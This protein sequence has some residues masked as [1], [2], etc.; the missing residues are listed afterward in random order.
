MSS[1]GTAE[2]S[3]YLLC[4]CP[5]C[6]AGGTSAAFAATGI[7]AAEA[8]PQAPAAAILYSSDSTVNALLFISD[9]YPSAR[10][11]YPSGG[12]IGDTTSGIGTGVALTYSFFASVPSYYNGMSGSLVP[13]NATFQAFTETQKAATRTALADVAAITGLTFTEVSDSGNG[14]QIRLGSHAMSGAGGYAYAPSTSWTGTSGDIWMN[15]YATNQDMTAGGYGYL[16]LLHEIGHALG[17]KHTFEGDVTLPTS[18]DTHQW[19]VMSY[20]EQP[21]NIIYTFSGSTATSKLLEPESYSVYDILALQYLYGVNT[22][23]RSGADTY[24]WAANAQFFDTIWDAGGTDTIDLSN[25]TLTSRISLTAGTQSSVNR[26]TTDAEKKIGW[27]NTSYSVPSNYFNGENNLG[28]AFGV[29]IE[30]VLLGSGNDSVIGNSADNQLTGNGGN[31]TLDGGA[32]TDTAIYKGASS[33][34]KIAVNGSTVTVTDSSGVEGVDTLTNI[35]FLKFSDKTVSATGSSTPTASVAGISVTEG[36]SGTTSATFTVTL[37]E[38][39]ATA[40]TMAYATASGTATSGVDFTAASGTLT[41]AA[42]QTTQTVSVAVIGD[43]AVEADETFTL[44]FTNPS[45]AL[46]AGG[47]TSLSA[48]GTIKND[49]SVASAAANDVLL[50]QINSPATTSAAVGND[51]YILSS[52]TLGQAGAYTLTDVQGSNSIQLV[53]GLTLS[54]FMVASN[55]LQMTLSSGAVVNVLDANL[56]TYDV[57]G[58]LAAGVDNTDV[59]F[60]AFVSSALGVTVPTTGL[61][62]GGAKTLGTAAGTATFV[63]SSA[64][65]TI[66]LPQQASSAVISSAAGNDTYLVSTGLLTAVGAYTITDSQG[67]NSIQFVG[68]TSISSFIVA[69]TALQ[70]TLS[71]GAVLTVLDADRFTYDIGGNIAA[72]RDNTDVSYAAFVSSVLGVT[73]PTS[74]TVAGG[75]KTVAFPA[76]P[77]TALVA[78]LGLTAEP[79]VL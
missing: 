34:Y 27:A 63:S 9:G 66:V 18:I 4:G 33:G 72:G 59:S 44:A 51:T 22:S 40:V 42:G 16:S 41:F 79:A 26:R 29:T 43:T 2:A 69:A 31:D 17:L 56:F 77:D 58:N 45:G 50:M 19:S 13:T 10:W 70:V 68:G 52:A 30:N 54:A 24:S 48:T 47:A 57:G 28:I 76:E 71:S 46:F 23:Y 6:A 25:Q 35:E 60:S 11:N 5:A 8:E 3:G 7:L 20:T 15:T 74:G 73:V 49:D 37:S 53:G 1:T 38:A 14:G 55:A 36:N 64:N 12:Y 39:A 32:G 61:V 67:S 21:N 75:S 65:D 62:T 78:L